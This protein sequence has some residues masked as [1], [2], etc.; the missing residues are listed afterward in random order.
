ML[1]PIVVLLLGYKPVGLQPVEATRLNPHNCIEFCLLKL[2]SIPVVIPR[3]T[4]A[5]A[6]FQHIW[7][8][9]QGL[10]FRRA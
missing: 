6:S 3:K 5:F 2:L 7:L 9:E 8:E 1:D 10:P 4:A